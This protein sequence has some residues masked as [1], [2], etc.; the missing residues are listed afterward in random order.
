MTVDVLII[1]AGVYGISLANSFTD[2][3]ISFAVTGNFMDMWRNHTFPEMKLRSDFKLSE[4]YD[5]QNNFSVDNFLKDYP[6]YEKYQNCHLPVSVFKFY[7][8]WIEKNISYH[9]IKSRIKLLDFS[10]KTSEFKATL[11][12]GQ[13]IGCKK[14]IIACGLSD[15]KFIPQGILSQHKNVLHSYDTAAISKLKKKNVL[16]VGTGQSAAECIETLLENKNEVKRFQRKTPV[17]L[18]QP[19]NIPRWLFQLI[20]KSGMIFYRLPSGIRNML[21]SILSTPTVMPSYR[22]LLDAMEIHDNLNHLNVFDVIVSATGYH[23]DSQNIPY[24]SAAIK[25]KLIQVPMT[26]LVNKNFESPVSGL[27]FSGPITSFVFGPSM[28]F[29][30]GARYTSERISSH[31]EKTAL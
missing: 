16:V 14:V 17:Y 8:K 13:I 21:N 9:I 18:E 31:L 22:P 25:N 30:A 12:N 29:I 28:K 27:F 5:P 3:K 11:D 23:F 26:K 4:I 6:E 20:D 2:K 19:V 7:L 1:G 24:L 15:F 10:P